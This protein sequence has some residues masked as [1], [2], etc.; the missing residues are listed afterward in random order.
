MIATQLYE[1][2]ADQHIGL[3]RK[4][5]QDYAHA[6]VSS[7]DV[8]TALLI[9]ADGIGGDNHPAG[10][11]AS[12]L[13]ATTISESLR[14][15][16]SPV[17][18]TFLPI[19][20]LQDKLRLAIQRANATIYNEGRRNPKLNDMGT[21]VACV[22][23]RGMQAVLAHVGDSRI[24]LHSNAVLTQLTNDHSAVSELV[25]KGFL[26]PD[27]IYNHPDRHIITRAL[28]ITPQVKID[29]KTIDLTP[30]DRLLLCTDGLWEMLYDFRIAHIL[31]AARTAQKAVNT[32]ISTAMDH[33]GVDNIGVV[34][35]DIRQE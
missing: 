12:A 29:I 30:G 35:C 9:V 8:P 14:P 19:E 2:A 15:E 21:T 32:L 28:G 16:L 23:V 5:N 25:Q 3:V 11:I 7:H 18:S 31:R 20:R 17:T 24:Y 4:T 27:E 10:D 22:L 6:W 1:A 34:V 26:E 13:A 33:G